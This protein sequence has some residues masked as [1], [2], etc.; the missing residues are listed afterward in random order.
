MNRQHQDVQPVAEPG[1]GYVQKGD[2]VARVD[3][4]AKVTGQA[5]Y[6]AE[7]SAPDMAFGVVVNST[8]AKGR[9][10]AM[11]L[12]RALAV[13]GVLQI[14]T[15]LNRPKTRKLDLF[16]KD[17]TAPAGSPFKPLHSEGILYSGQPIALVLA[18]TFEAARHAASLVTVDYA[19]EP[20]DT[21][22]LANLHR[23][24]KPSRL[25][26][27]FTPPPSETGD[28]Q[29]AFDAAPVKIKAEFYSG[30]EHH[31]PMEMHATTVLRCEDGHLTIYDKTQSSQNSRWQVSRVFGLPKRQVTVRNPFVGGAFGSG[32][33]P[34]YNLILACSSSARCAW[35][36][37]ASRCSRLA[38]GPR[39]GSGYSWRPMPM[40]RCRP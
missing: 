19:Q 1:T 5:R 18:D 39:P 3:G 29:A 31:N 2:A 35:C 20:H 21:S 24:R 14:L 27:G 7:H 11:H 9:I 32:L 13:P 28:A 40:A 16:Y 33:R 36:S 30:V 15:H 8:I 25:K 37:R 38:T 23:H 10:T 26:A 12:E 34:Q 4:R 17:M 22:L 6:A